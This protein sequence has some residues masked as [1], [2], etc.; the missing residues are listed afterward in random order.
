MNIVLSADE[1]QASDEVYA[2]LELILVHLCHDS[3]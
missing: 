1:K 3:S 2:K